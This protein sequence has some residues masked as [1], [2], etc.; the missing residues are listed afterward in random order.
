MK[1]HKVGELTEHPDGTIDLRYW[2]AD[3]DP[4]EIITSEVNRQELI[5]LAKQAGTY[6][7]KDD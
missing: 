4:K 3:I 7:Y 1:V 6:A 2:I 5:R